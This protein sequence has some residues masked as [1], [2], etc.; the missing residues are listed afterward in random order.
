MEILTNYSIPFSIIVRIISC[1]ILAI[2]LIPLQIKEAEVKN[3]LRVLRIQLLISGLI[4]FFTNLFSIIFF[5][6]TLDIPQK[7]LHNS[8]QTINSLS[9]LA[10]SLIA[11][12]IYRTQY[13]DEAKDY[14]E[15][16]DKL[17]KEAEVKKNKNI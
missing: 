11:Q 7:P 4:L 1:I 17:E 6:I 13:T 3:G 5:F 8:I 9:F 14:H 16:I 2:F 12:A 10:L 15:K